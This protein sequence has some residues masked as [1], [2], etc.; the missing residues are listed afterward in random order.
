MQ[1]GVALQV[2]NA[3]LQIARS[4][5]Q[6]KSSLQEAL[7]AA[8]ENRELNVRAYQQEIVET[9][10]VIEAQLMEF[11]CTDNIYACSSDHQMNT[12]SLE[13]IIGNNIYE[14][15]LSTELALLVVCSYLFFCLQRKRNIRGTMCYGIFRLAMVDIDP[16]DADAALKIWA[17]EMGKQYGFKV[18]TS[19]YQSLD[20]MVND[21]NAKKIDFASMSSI[22]YLR[23]SPTLKVNRK[24][25]DIE[26]IRQP[27]NIC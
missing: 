27:Q 5:A 9:K 23:L 24:W 14:N 4:Q 7:A 16:K 17:Q 3:F 18:E 10:D 25:H 22:D 2:K 13:F 11:S 20:M 1:E 15:R 6:V 26:V 8:T 12:G 21:F 19:L